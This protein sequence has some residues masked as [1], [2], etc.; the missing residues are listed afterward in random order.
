MIEHRQ[1]RNFIVVAETLHFSKAAQRLHL[2]QPSLSRQ[3]AALEAEVGVTLFARH[4]RSVA[5]TAAG[6]EFLQHARTITGALDLAVRST[7]AATRGERGELHVS[8]TS[9]AAWTLLP[10]LLKQYTDAHPAVTLNLNELLPKDLGPAVEKGETDLALTFPMPDRPQLR[11]HRLHAEPLCAVLPANHP[12][13]SAEPFDVSLLSQEPFIACPRVNAPL[14]HDAL[15]NGCRAAGFEPQIR[16]Q[17]HL[18][19]TIVNLVAEGL[20]VS[21]VPTSMRKMQLPGVVFKSIDAPA[22]IEFGVAW[23]PDNENPC[24]MTFLRGVGAEI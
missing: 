6:M 22:D 24:L 9:V 18:Q 20:G 10:A 3:I 13:A 16:I 2:T 12:L 19:Q 8:F 11:Y 23:N 14:M 1:L 15:M 5:L 4:S 7:R 17:T 21:L